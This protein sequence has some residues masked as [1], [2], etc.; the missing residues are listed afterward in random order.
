[1][2]RDTGHVLHGSGGGIGA[3]LAAEMH[4][5]DGGLGEFRFGLGGGGGLAGGFFAFD[6]P[7]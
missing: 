2:L 3:L 5:G 1:V 4:A 7:K 6:L